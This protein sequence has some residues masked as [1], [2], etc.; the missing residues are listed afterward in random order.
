MLGMHGPMALGPL[1]RI[2][3]W[4]DSWSGDQR[5]LQPLQATYPFCFLNL[6][7]KEYLTF[8]CQRSRIPLKWNREYSGISRVGTGVV[9][10]GE[11]GLTPIFPD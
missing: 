4:G 6:I 2:P 3:L 5:L 8:G 7:Y 9:F 1:P 11:A 10:P